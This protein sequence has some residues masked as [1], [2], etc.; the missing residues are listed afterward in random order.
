MSLFYGREN[1]QWRTRIKLGSESRESEVEYI[2]G[3]S[4]ARSTENSAAVDCRSDAQVVG[5]SGSAN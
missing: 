4:C 1:F 3:K 2:V 5:S